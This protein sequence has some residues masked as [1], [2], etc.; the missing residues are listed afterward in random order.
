M[1]STTELDAIKALH[2]V[3]HGE[4]V[5]GGLLG[6]GKY[7]KNNQLRLGT[8]FSILLDIVNMAR[9]VAFLAEKYPAYFR[10]VNSG[11]LEP[12]ATPLEQ[13]AGTSIATPEETPKDIHLTREES[14]EAML[15]FG[16]LPVDIQNAIVGIS[17]IEANDPDFV[18]WFECCK[19][20]RFN[21][22]EH[23]QLS[24]FDTKLTLDLKCTETHLSI[25]YQLAGASKNQ[26]GRCH[27]GEL[28]IL[29]RISA[30]HSSVHGSIPYHLVIRIGRTVKGPGEAI[31]HLNLTG[32]I[33]IIGPPNMGKTTLI[34]DI[35]RIVAELNEEKNVYV[36]D[37]CGEIAGRKSIQ[38]EGIGKATRLLVDDRGSQAACMRRAVENLSANVIVVD[39]I[40][41]SNEA[42]ECQRI[43]TRSVRTIATI[44][45]S[46]MAEALRNKE[47]SGIFG[48]FQTV[49]LNAVEKK[50]AFSE[51]KSVVEVIQE[52]PFDHCIELESYT[53]WKVHRDV[54]KLVA[55]MVASK[56]FEPLPLQVNLIFETDSASPM[57][58]ST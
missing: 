39:E 18:T 6:D 42:K 49:I 2:R 1:S 21:L 43:S 15:L 52:S 40:T 13:N 26:D 50:N 22:G 57:I 55:K 46:S 19:E 36:I 41:N 51:N 37:T 20:L 9:P 14:T 47:T 54:K 23:I 25:L 53:S 27:G 5:N 8:H 10:M 35:T 31:M 45:G 34:R 17:N 11:Y 3:M 7:I 28:G 32:N 24:N 16:K 33:L 38:H 48:E 56:T 12:L 30:E 4:R 44:H 29:N 58:P